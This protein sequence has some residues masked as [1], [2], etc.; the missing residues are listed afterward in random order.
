MDYYTRKQRRAWETVK[1]LPEALLW[2]VIIGLLIMSV[3]ANASADLGAK[4]NIVLASSSADKIQE[5][6]LEG[7]RYAC[8]DLLREFAEGRID[9]AW[10]PSDEI[11]AWWAN[12]IETAGGDEVME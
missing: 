5:H 2:A 4:V 9:P 8:L 12:E 10:M 6:C 7:H 11:V 1:M 3:K